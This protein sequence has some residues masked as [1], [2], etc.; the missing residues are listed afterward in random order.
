MKTATELQ[1]RGYHT[2]LFGH[3]NHI[4]YLEFLED[5]RWDFFQR[6]PSLGRAHSEENLIHV[7]AAMNLRYLRSAK[8]G[9]NLRVETELSEVSRIRLRFRQRI[10]QDEHLILEADSTAAFVNTRT[11]KPAR[12]GKEIAAELARTIPDSAAQASGI[13]PT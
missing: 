12:L 7:M 8:M 3:V 9:A 4:R 10:Y 1:V 5:G 11:G 2:D 13:D 6:N